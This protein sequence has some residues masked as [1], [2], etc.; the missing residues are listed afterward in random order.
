MAKS[1]SFDLTG[2]VIIV[3]GAGKGIGKA[4]ALAAAEYG[5]DVALGSRTVSECEATAAECRALGRRAEAWPLDVSK[6]ESINE[7]VAK[8]W[9]AFGRIDSVV[10]NA[11]YNSPKPAL[12]YSEEEFDYISD[13]NFKG[14]FFMSTAVARR[15]IEHNIEGSVITISSQVGVVGGPLRAI[16]AAAKG[17]VGQFTRSLAAEWAANKITVNAVAPTFTRTP[18][19]E[20]A[21]ENPAFAKN[22]EKVPMG[23]IAE[24]E[25]IAA[26]V[27]Y[28]ASDA[29]RMVTGQ[30]LVVDGGFTSV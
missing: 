4:I 22:L 15:M 7:F 21:L 2:K 11:G 27:I 1:V 13:V 23:R 26:A 14:A 5:A 10:N 16:Y 17:A 28:L 25:E 6:V 30:T 19:L 29:A 20:K 8:T 12:D 9:D 18:L 3:T 24:P